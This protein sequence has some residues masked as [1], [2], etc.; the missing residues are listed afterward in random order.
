MTELMDWVKVLAAT[1]DLLK[2]GVNW[3]RSLQRH[4]LDD[5]VKQRWE[6]ELRKA[7]LSA[8][9]AATIAERFSNEV[10]TQLSAT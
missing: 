6:A 5:E 10:A 1:F 2:G 4:Q 9:R 3:V 8:K 7:G